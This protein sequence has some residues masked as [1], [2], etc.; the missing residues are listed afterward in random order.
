MAALG[1]AATSFLNSCSDDFEQPP[2]AVPVSRW[3]VDE[4]SENYDDVLQKK[5]ITYIN[6]SDL[7]E[8]Y[9]N[10]NS[11]YC[12]AIGLD[13]NGDSLVVKGRIISADSSGNIYKKFVIYD[14]TAA[15]P[16][17]VNMK[18]IYKEFHFGQEV[19]VNLTGIHV[20]KYANLFQVGA[21]D[22]YAQGLDGL[23]TTFLDET[24][25]R[26]HAQANGWQEQ[27]QVD[28]LS[29]SLSDI[30]K[31]K[32]KADIIKNMSRLVRIDNVY[33]QEAGQPYSTTGTTSNRY[34][35]DKAGNSLCVRLSGYSDFYWNTIPGGYGT[36]VGILSQFNQ[37]LQLELIG[38]SGVIG[39]D[40][41]AK[42]VGKSEFV[43]ATSIESGKSYALVADNQKLASPIAADRTFGYFYVTDV[44][45]ENNRFDGASASSFIFTKVEK[46]Y[47]IQQQD[48][49]YIYQ[50]E[51]K[52]N[53]DLS[54]TLGTGDEYVWT[55]TFDNDGLATITNVGRGRWIQYSSNYT[56]YGSYN[57]VQT[58][59]F[60]PA[61]YVATE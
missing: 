53:F 17:S 30:V 61:L 8:K 52:N 41:T 58:G 59:G 55:V 28:T 2:Y 37:T 16:V 32:D 43:K 46:G 51:G 21:P 1:L 38:I 4:N 36:V 27:E 60:L 56:S 57:S 44:T 12:T 42:P 24:T 20:G 26:L 33:W 25:F 39:F 34:I 29:I 49:R 48:G 11:N 7:K 13:E 14:G 45:I 19:F 31:I 18:E 6:I 10:D 15:L 23:Q 50:S 22:S 40:P 35:C 54:E 47:T 3:Y 5:N 9:W